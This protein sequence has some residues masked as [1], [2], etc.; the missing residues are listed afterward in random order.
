MIA[1]DA[2]GSAEHDRNTARDH[3]G[4]IRVLLAWVTG[5]GP[6]AMAWPPIANGAVVPCVLPRDRLVGAGL[7]ANAGH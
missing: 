5:S 7:A 1:R 3:G 6:G 2:A 4:V